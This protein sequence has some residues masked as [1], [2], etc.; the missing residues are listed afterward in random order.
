MLALRVSGEFRDRKIVGKQAKSS[1]DTGFEREC[2][3]QQFA[4]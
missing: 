2:A 1:T 4:D 3:C